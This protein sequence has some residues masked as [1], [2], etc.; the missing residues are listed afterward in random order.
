MTPSDVLVACTGGVVEARFWS[1]A[2]AFL[3][4][5]PDAPLALDSVRVAESLRLTTAH[6]AQGAGTAYLDWR[7]PLRAPPGLAIYYTLS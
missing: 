6:M 4:R 1:S 5:A 2:P 3:F 7:G